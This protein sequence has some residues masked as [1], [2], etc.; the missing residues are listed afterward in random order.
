METIFPTGF[1]KQTK[2]AAEWEYEIGVDPSISSTGV[3]IKC[4]KGCNSDIL[5]GWTTKKRLFTTFISNK[6][7]AKSCLCA[8]Y[9]EINSTLKFYFPKVLYRIIMHYIQSPKVLLTRI[10]KYPDLSMVSGYEERLEQLA[11]MV[12]TEIKRFVS[13]G[14]KCAFTFEAPIPV[15]QRTTDLL[16]RDFQIVLRLKIYREYSKCNITE[17]PA[18]TIKKRW[19]GKGNAKKPEMYAR[20]HA[21]YAAYGFPTFVPAANT[22]YGFPEPFTGAKTEHHPLQDMV[23]A[24]AAIEPPLP[25]QSTTRKR[26]RQAIMIPD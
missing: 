14:T 1:H 23:D 11:T 7:N 13:V 16:L 18:A 4:L 21:Y 2:M 12:L 9:A 17:V 10:V 24:R 22:L 6:N 3:A 8:Y 25:Q 19:T 5:I 26:K 15:P 20:F